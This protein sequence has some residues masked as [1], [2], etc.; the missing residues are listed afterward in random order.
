MDIPGISTERRKFES[1][2]KCF[3]Q[4]SLGFGK[5]GLQFCLATSCFVAGFIEVLTH[6]NLRTTEYQRHFCRSKW[7]TR[8][9]TLQ[10]L[11]APTQLTFY[12]SGWSKIASRGTLASTISAATNISSKYLQGDERAL[13]Q[14]S[15]AQ[16]M[17][18]LS[19]RSTT[20]IEDIAYCVLGI[21]DIN[22]PLLYGE[23]SKAFIRLQEEIIKAS[24]DHT[25]FC[26][27]WISSV[28]K[29]W[30]SHLSFRS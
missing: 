25:I 11:L 22:M 10:E 17:A 2:L 4:H 8:G 16:K 5:C 23:G 27:T 21:F 19:S 20:R 12:A 26:W 7:F 14:A 28:P 1:G 24:N 3:Y 15:A 18:W 9:W 29:D 13:S 30:V 6:E